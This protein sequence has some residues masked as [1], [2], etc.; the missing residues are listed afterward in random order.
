MTVEGI[1]C[2]IKTETYMGWGLSLEFEGICITGVTGQGVEA[3]HS[4]A[5]DC[6]EI[7]VDMRSL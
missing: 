5:L 2:T 3:M 1:H 6:D 7:S 4:R